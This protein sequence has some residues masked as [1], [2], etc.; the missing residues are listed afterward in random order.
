MVCILQA[1]VLRIET[2]LVTMCASGRFN[3][4]V[5]TSRRTCGAL[6]KFLFHLSGYCPQNFAG[7]PYMSLW[8]TRFVWTV[9]THRLTVTDRTPKR[10]LT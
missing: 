2:Q 4:A 6:S 7:H 8:M 10:N 9:S 5:S 1:R 3:C